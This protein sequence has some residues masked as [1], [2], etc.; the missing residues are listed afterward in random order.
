V[1]PLYAQDRL[2]GECLANE[3]EWQFLKRTMQA[4]CKTSRTIMDVEG[5]AATI[6]VK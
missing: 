5:Q 4:M 6:N 1:G 3:H 2:F